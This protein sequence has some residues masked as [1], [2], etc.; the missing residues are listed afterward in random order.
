MQLERFI[1]G[2][3]LYFIEKLEN[4]ESNCIHNYLVE[5]YLFF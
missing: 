2:K 4:K 3:E 1:L 5:P